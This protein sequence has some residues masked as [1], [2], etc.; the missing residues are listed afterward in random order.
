MKNFISAYSKTT[1]I[2]FLLV[3]FLIFNLFLFPTLMIQGNPLDLKFFYTGQEAYAFIEG[4]GE[5]GRNQ[6]LTALLYLD[7]AYPIIY[8]LLF[9]FI[10][11]RL[12]KDFKIAQLPFLVLLADYLENLG[13]IL[14]LS[15]YP[16]KLFMIGNIS[17]M[18]TTLKWD[19]LI[20]IFGMLVF[21]VIKKIT[22]SRK[23]RISKSNI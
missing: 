17:G 16:E 18:F 6:Y 22:Q 7:F 21:G 15:F 12:F 13:T 3:L 5:A 9:S 8:S 14:M 19:L 23:P 10:L 2:I 4:Y 11:F 20:F 1:Y